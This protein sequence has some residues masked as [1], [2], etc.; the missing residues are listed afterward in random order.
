MDAIRTSTTMLALGAIASA[1]WAQV[2]PGHA[3]VASNVRDT[4]Q[5]FDLDL[6]TGKHV[7]LAPFPGSR[8]PP[9][10]LTVDPVSRDIFVIVDAGS[11][12]SRCERLRYTGTKLVRSRTIAT[13]PGIVRDVVMADA[14]D[15]FLADSVG[16]SRL[17][18][19]GRPTR[20]A[21]VARARALSTFGAQSTQAW[22]A[23]SGN[24]SAPPGLRLIDLTTGKTAAGPF[25][26]TGFAAQITG[27]VDLPTGLI[28]QLVT[29]SLGRLSVSIG[30]KVPVP[31]KMTP[32]LPAGATR[33]MRY[34]MSKLDAYVLGGS[35]HPY[36]K[37]MRGWTAQAWNIR[38]GPFPGDP[39]AFDLGPGSAPAIES[40]GKGCDR[41]GAASPFA[42][43]PG[44]G[45]IPRLGNGNFQ[46]IATQ[47]PLAIA[48]IFFVFGADEIPHVALPSPC[49][50][51]VAP[52]LIFAHM[53]DRA[54]GATQALPIPNDARFLG[55]TFYGQ[56][57]QPRIGASV[58]FATSS[59]AACH[60]R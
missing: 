10:A 48:P 55:A 31:L 50:L 60:V 12:T 29:D 2:E 24:A 3:I 47:A 25:V 59:A 30:F 16:L 6:A 5:L 35:A 20:V 41:F 19:F 7:S 8:R 37:T 39:V 49:S 46:L 15:L 40:F 53:T 18:R 57:V 17:R 42:I 52:D 51:R 1:A 14:S 11:S 28:R 43:R 44:Q 56:W 54:M 34:D 58:Q 36:V 13:F 22:V 21:N 23:H 9:L 27:V 33:A 38:G 4:T 45:S 32:T 26:Y